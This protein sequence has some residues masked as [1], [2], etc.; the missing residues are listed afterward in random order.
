MN[1]QACT[2]YVPEDPALFRQTLERINWHYG[3]GDIK[4]IDYWL[5]KAYVKKQYGSRWYK[6]TLLPEGRVRFRGTVR[7]I[8]FSL[9]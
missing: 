2:Y 9:R 6:Y 8:G 7:K 4:I 3:N 1:T 5:G